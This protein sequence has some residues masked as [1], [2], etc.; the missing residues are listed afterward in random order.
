L[1]VTL[2]NLQ[3]ASGN[4]QIATTNLPAISDALGLEA[5]DLPGLGGAHCRSRFFLRGALTAARGG[6]QP[7]FSPFSPN[8]N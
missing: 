3:S 2:K 4:L 8:G 1:Q 7:T 6:F 5:R